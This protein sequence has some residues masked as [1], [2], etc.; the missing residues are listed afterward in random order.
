MLSSVYTVVVVNGTAAIFYD[1]YDEC[2]KHL[3][4]VQYTCSSNYY[5][6]TQLSRA[7]CAIFEYFNMAC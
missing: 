6:R 5:S 2:D 1:D 4:S 7:R 3:I